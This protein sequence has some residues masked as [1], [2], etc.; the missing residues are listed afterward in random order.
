MS[1]EGGKI[2]IYLYP[3]FP[4]KSK[5]NKKIKIKAHLLLPNNE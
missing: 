3:P 5:K 1:N 2:N 4:L